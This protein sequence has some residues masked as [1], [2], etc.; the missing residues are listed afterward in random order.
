M[1]NH[2]SEK[3]QAL[4]IITFAIIGLIGL[5]G[6]AVDGGMAYASQRKAQS[7]ADTAAYAV[8]LA[9]LKGRDT[10]AAANSIIS[11]NGGQNSEVIV[12]NPPGPGCNGVTPTY[13]NNNEYIQVI[14]KSK[15]KTSF[16]T[17]V[18]IKEVNNCADA[19]THATPGTTGS[20]FNGA[21]VVALKE[22]GQGTF[23]FN[24][25]AKINITGNS[26]IM[27]NSNDPNSLYLNGSAKLT[28]DTGIVSCNNGTTYINANDK[29]DYINGG[30]V[31]D[32]CTAVSYT[33]PTDLPTFPVPPAAP[34]CT[35][36]GSTDLVNKVIHPGSFSGSP[37]FNN[38]KNETWTM[39]AGTYCFSGDF[40]LQD[41]NTIKITGGIATLVFDRGTYSSSSSFNI[42]NGATVKTDHPSTNGL[43]LYF[44]SSNDSGKLSIKGTLDV[45]IFRYYG[46]NS[47]TLDINDANSALKSGDG[48]IYNEKASMDNWNSG[49]TIQLTAPTSGD[50][51]GLVYYSPYSNKSTIKFN[52]S[53]NIELNGTMYCPGADVHANGNSNLTA[54]NTQIIGYTISIDGNNNMN[55][56]YDASKSP[57]SPS[58]AKITLV[59]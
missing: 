5:T 22:S 2:K 35:K 46:F 45:D 7:T 23:Y 21:S 56:H 51:K 15:T 57:S 3:G 24:G 27:V 37:N 13:T 53:S 11:A 59:K 1:K 19:V 55:I 6:L 50:Y 30:T 36:V 12:N 49:S 10:T 40:N 17:I 31:T 47:A 28:T 42:N 32:N 34:T 54:W 41:S 26:G 52:G 43:T 48:F 16:G 38:G 8:A 58:A 25:G 18:G 20:F 29:K 39:E 33:L 9:K 44:P 14:I 4:I